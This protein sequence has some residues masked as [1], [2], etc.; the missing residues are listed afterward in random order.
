MVGKSIPHARS[1]TTDHVEKRT[2]EFPS[3]K[4]VHKTTALTFKQDTDSSDS[5]LKMK[6]QIQMIAVRMKKIETHQMKG[7]KQDLTMSLPCH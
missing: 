5:T 1:N 3:G 7:R 6:N 2:E 4:K